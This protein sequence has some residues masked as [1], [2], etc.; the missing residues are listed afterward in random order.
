MPLGMPVEPEVKKTAAGASAGG[1][2]GSGPG[3]ACNSEGMFWSVISNAISA[4]GKSKGTATAP[5]R[6]Q[7]K[8]AQINSKLLGSEI[9]TF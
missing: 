7:P 1:C 5:A 2:G 9:K 4:P 6:K 3:L 8:K